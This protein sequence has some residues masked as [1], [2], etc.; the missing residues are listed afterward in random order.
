MDQ[1]WE[2]EV[3]NEDYQ[4]QVRR[5]EELIGQLEVWCDTYTINHK[6]EEARLDDYV[7]LSKN[8]YEQVEEIKESIALFK[9][10]ENDMQ[11]VAD[12]ESMLESKLATF[13][14]TESQI[15]EWVR[16]I[17]TLDTMLRNSTILNKHREHIEYLLGL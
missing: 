2:L 14:P 17:K 8:F 9:M 11:W 5:L 13:K 15:N 16:D 10:Q 4:G 3:F 12:Q 6:K 7:V 1:N